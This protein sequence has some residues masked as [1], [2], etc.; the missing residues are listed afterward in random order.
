MIRRRAARATMLPWV[1][2]SKRSPA[3]L[4]A[5]QPTA[6]HM[7]T[8][9]SA[10]AVRGQAKPAECRRGGGKK[11]HRTRPRRTSPR[12][13]S[14]SR[15]PPTDLHRHDYRRSNACAKSWRSTRHGARPC[16]FAADRRAG[17]SKTTIWTGRWRFTTE[18]QQGRARV[19]RGRVVRSGG[20]ATAGGPLVRCARHLGTRG[21]AARPQPRRNGRTVRRPSARGR[22]SGSTSSRARPEVLQA[23]VDAQAGPTRRARKTFRDAGRLLRASTASA[24]GSKK[25]TATRLVARPNDYSTLDGAGRPDRGNAGRERESYTVPGPG[26]LFLARCGGFAARAGR[27]RRRRSAKTMQAIAHQRRL[28]ALPGQAT[29]EN[30]EKLADLQNERPRR[31]RGGADLG[32]DRGDSS[33]AIRTRLE[34]GAEFFEGNDRQDRPRPRTLYRQV[35]RARCQR[36]PAGCSISPGWTADAGDT[37]D[38]RPTPRTASSPAPIPN[39]PAT[40]CCRRRNWISRRRPCRAS[41]RG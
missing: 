26:V 23:A 37:A 20:R 41:S 11:G 34:R 16:Q 39:G 31:R 33:R 9:I 13:N 29:A 35:A 15:F 30:V 14:S 2:T 21:G 36:S 40:P 28:T 38:A 4:A 27:C 25:N 10:L 17:G 3:R 32:T 12:G 5:D 22:T 18:L 6:D 24:I 7:L 1:I 19:R 8:A